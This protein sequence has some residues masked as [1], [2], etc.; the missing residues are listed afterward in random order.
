[1]LFC[2]YCSIQL[3]FDNIRPHAGY[4]VYFTTG[5]EMHAENGLFT[6][7]NPGHRLLHGYGSFG[8]RVHTPN[9]IWTGSVILHGSLTIVEQ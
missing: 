7:E 9:G 3:K 4:S 5:W 6:W 2:D 8:P 1:M